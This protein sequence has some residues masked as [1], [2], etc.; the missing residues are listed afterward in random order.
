LCGE[1]SCRLLQPLVLRREFWHELLGCDERVDRGFKQRIRVGRF[2]K[3]G[4]DFEKSSLYCLGLVG[5]KINEV[6]VCCGPDLAA[7]RQLRAS[8]FMLT[9]QEGLDVV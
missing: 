6:L 7:L 2:G 8:G 9:L 4:V 1:F 5:Y 3:R